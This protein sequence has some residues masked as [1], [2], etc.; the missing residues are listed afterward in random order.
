MPT[1]A[2]TAL[3]RGMRTLTRN[4]GDLFVFG[5][6]SFRATVSEPLQVAMPF[7]RGTTPG[8]EYDLELEAALEDIETEI[9]REGQTLTRDGIK[10]RV[11][12]VRKPPGT[13]KVVFL[14]TLPK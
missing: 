7:G 4:V 6:R 1:P 13:H 5:G 3:A 2:Q 8:P 9:P 12:A 11:A 14:V 10:Y